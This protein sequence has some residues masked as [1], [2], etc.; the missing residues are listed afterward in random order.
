MIAL[1]PLPDLSLPTM[2]W[3]TLAILGDY[4]GGIVY[5][6]AAPRR[7]RHPEDGMAVGCLMLAIIPALVTALLVVAGLAW[8]MPPLVRWPFNVCVV[9][10]AYVVLVVAAQPVAK[11]WRL[12]QR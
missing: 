6:L 5:A 12:R 9:V 7:Q 1:W 4:V 10:F 11:A 8:G 3:I 2:A